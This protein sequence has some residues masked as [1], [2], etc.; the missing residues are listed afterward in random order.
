MSEAIRILRVIARLNTGGPAIHVTLATAGLA[1]AGYHTRLL[2]GDVADGESSMEWFSEEHGVRVERVDGLGREIRFRDVGVVRALSRLIREW[3]PHI[4]HTHTAKAGAV[5]RAAALTIRRSRRPKLVHTFHGHVLSGYFGAAKQAAFRAIERG[6]AR[7]TDRLVVPGARLRDELLVLGV[8]RAA[9][10]AVVPLGFDLSRFLA[11]EADSTPAG[12]GTIRGV[13]GIPED[14]FAIGIVGRLTRVKNHR[15][16]ID[17]FARMPPARAPA[18]LVVV[19]DGELR[20]EIEAYAKA[21]GVADRVRFTGS[22]TD[23]P[24]I[25]RALDVVALSSDAEGTPVALIEAMASAR[26]VVSTD[27][28]SVRDIVEDRVHGIVV[29]PGDAVALAAA[30]AELANDASLRHTLGAAGRKHAG[31]A[32]GAERLL[33]DLDALY[34]SL[35]DG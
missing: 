22:A 12:R 19:G 2:A 24:A 31:K 26:P 3:R 30:L 25:Y 9:Q 32:F 27:V 16:M 11:I 35:L 7:K 28:G 6:L 20:R 14:A 33:R 1:A 5:G 8:G 21:C 17:A 18:I 23:M 34:R 10:Y 15:L 29:P 13:H 4:V